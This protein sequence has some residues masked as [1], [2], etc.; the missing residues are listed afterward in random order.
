MRHT[1]VAL[2][3]FLSLATLNPVFA[4]DMELVMESEP[5]A[6]ETFSI[7]VKLDTVSEDT[8]GTDLLIKFVPSQLE[9]SE[10]QPGELYANYH[11]ARLDLK[12]GTIR[13]SGT[14]DKDNPFSGSG[15]FATLVFK[16]LYDTQSVLPPAESGDKPL[17]GLIWERD[18]TTDTNVVSVGGQEILYTAPSVRVGGNVLGVAAVGEGPESDFGLLQETATQMRSKYLLIG[19][20]VAVIVILILPIIIRRRSKEDEETQE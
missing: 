1:I 20:I 8:I 10:I 11:E 18:A 19:A 13:Y 17:V 7:D 2:I 5:A 9:F 12:T 3:A 6:N 4:A 15:T 16:K 14:V